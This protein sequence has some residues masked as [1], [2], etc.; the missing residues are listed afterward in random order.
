M[1]TQ[2]KVRLVS[3]LTA[4]LAAVG[5]VVLP[6]AGGAGEARAAGTEDSAFTAPGR[7]GEYDDFSDLRVTVHQ[8]K[9]LRGQGVNISWTG[10]KQ[11]KGA[12]ETNFLQ[13]MQCWGDDPGGPRREQCQ[14]GKTQTLPDGVRNRSLAGSL[15]GYQSSEAQYDLNEIQYPFVPTPGNPQQGT[16]GFVPF[17]PVSGEPTTS[18]TDHTYFTQFT[19]NEQ[20][21]LSTGPDGTGEAIFEVQT[22]LESDHLGC[23]AVEGGA[24]RTCWLVIIPRGEHD[25]N[26]QLAGNN[27]LASSALSASN[28]AN[29]IAV[30]L[31]FEP[32]GA[33][34]PLDLR[35][36]S[37]YGSE[38]LTE[39][40]GSWQAAL[41]DSKDV[42]FNHIRQGEEEA[43]G[44]VGTGL[45][46]TIAPVGASEDSDKVVHAPMAVSGLVIGYNV[47]FP[48]SS[49]QMPQLRLNARLVAKLLTS[50][51]HHDLPGQGAQRGD[52]PKE[53]PRTLRHDPEFLE[54]NPE[55]REGWPPELNMPA[56]I[57]VPQG[58]SDYARMLWRWLQNDKHAREFLAGKE[59]P[60]GAKVNSHYL[61]LHLDQD[62]AIS[63]FPKADPISYSPNVGCAEMKV[64]LI[65]YRPYTGSLHDSG[66]RAR[67]GYNG[68]KTG[69]DCTSD[70]RRLIGD[71]QPAGERFQLALVDAATAARYGLGTVEVRNA[72]GEWVKPGT[73]SFSKAVAGMMKTPE[74]VLDQD[75]TLKTEGAYPLTTV[76]YGAASTGLGAEMRRDYADLIRY[77]AG[78]GQEPGI[79]PGKLPP[80]YAPLSEEMRKQA[81]QAAD[82]LAKQQPGET[83]GSSSGH[84]G[85]GSSGGGG[86][87]GGDGGASGGADSG[88][89]GGGSPGG[90]SAPDSSASPAPAGAPDGPD[91]PDKGNIAQTGPLTPEKILGFIRWVL[92]ATL[93]AGIVGAAAGP[94][95]MRVGAMRAA[96]A[97]GSHLE[98]NSSTP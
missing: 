73:G 66:L 52:L 33:N 34:C 82:E 17:Q 45:G 38:I 37:I 64:D 47:E 32:I 16:F 6:Q 49:R 79:E 81:L 50:S 55:F 56:G 40:T 44:Q 78:P 65:D 11:T 76:I 72:N 3:G 74:G 58:N 14:F 42:S 26:G 97:P 89:P 39:A 84:S 77:A 90:E 60:W 29:R 25:A 10:G 88:G 41:C 48:R 18:P 83:G 98:G 57:M 13:V 59:D 4:L 51:Y 24:A 91:G 62:D 8:T 94:I 67:K 85:G 95:L 53:N 28:W 7:A 80:G 20:P 31:E 1:R 15:V 46:L 35:A 36:R 70:P 2:R 75:P 63:D 92:L 9:G 96:G 30:K 12:F 19:T 5:L 54:L 68:Q 69:A 87:S 86:A 27:G 71:A 93:I 23:G 21:F 43:R 61:A 22:A